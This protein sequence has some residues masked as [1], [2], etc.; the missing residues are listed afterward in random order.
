MLRYEIKGESLPVVICYPSAGQTLISERGAMSWM[1]PNMQMN[2]EATGG[3]GKAFGRMLTKESIFQN[4]YTAVGGNGLIA[5]ASSFPGSIIAFDVGQMGEVIVQKSGFLASE[6]TVNLSTYFQKKLG[7]GLF[8]GEGFIMQSL[9]GSGVAFVEIDGSVTEYNLG[10][11]QSLILD[12]G[13]LAAMVGCTMDVETVPGLKNMFFGGEGVF[14][15]KVTGGPNGGKIWVQSM[16]LAQT[17]LCLKPYIVPN[18][19]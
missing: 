4:K 11:G 19:R 17:A 13:Y 8:G 3:I 10:P 15:T 1:S 5:F 16:P 7:G 12:T 2:T 6:D 18:N 9:T 14:N